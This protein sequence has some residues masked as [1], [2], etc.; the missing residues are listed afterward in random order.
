MFVRPSVCPSVGFIRVGLPVCLAVCL[1]VCLFVCLFVCLLSLSLVCVCWC[2]SLFVCV[3]V[4]CVCICARACP[5]G[6]VR[7][8]SR[9]LK[10][11]IPFFG[12]RGQYASETAAVGNYSVVRCLSCGWFLLEYPTC[13]TVADCN[14]RICC[15]SML[16]YAPTTPSQILQSGKLLSC[17]LL[18]VVVPGTRMTSC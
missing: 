6:H 11:S 10:G 14:D 16:P 15:C 2:L 3:C 17:M 8:N 1:S 4:L 5:C 13:S 18:K 9:E 12:H 7:N